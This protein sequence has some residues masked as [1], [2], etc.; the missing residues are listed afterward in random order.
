ML[1]YFTLVS[2]SFKSMNTLMSSFR[3]SSI[4]SSS[5]G[6]CS[7]AKFRLQSNTVETQAHEIIN[8]NTLKGECLLYL[9]F[10][11]LPKLLR[12]LSCLFRRCAGVFYRGIGQQLHLRSGLRQI[13][14]H[15]SH[16]RGPLRG[17]I[18]IMMFSIRFD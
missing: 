12:T 9:K 4:A 15:C 1:K 16:C 10:A 17:K 5:F 14:Q 18:L 8:E 2:L 13:L 11:A 7:P 3:H 6:T